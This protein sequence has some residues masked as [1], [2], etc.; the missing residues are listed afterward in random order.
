MS[1]IEINSLSHTYTQGNEDYPVLK[2]I[3]LVIREG[4]F[5]A[6][7]GPSG[8]GKS[9]LLSILA[10]LE[11]PTKG[12]YQLAGTSVTGLNQDQ[13]AMLRGKHIGI[14]FQSFNLIGDMTLAENIQLPLK[15]SSHVSA[16]RHSLLVENAIAAVGLTD[17]ADFYPDMLSGGQQQRAAI[18]RAIVHQPDILFADEPTGN[19][20]S[21]TGEHI[22]N[23][24]KDL[25]DKGMTLCMVTHD[26]SIAQQANS[27]LF[28]QDGRISDSV[29]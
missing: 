28:M 3:N 14:I 12:A 11:R 15:L 13:R 7:C 8:H 27:R 20:D 17:K 6:I 4:E 29:S 24:L 10:L 21:T 9:T 26:K 25:N 2:E 5:T 23:L 19:L 18:A 16:E 1:L 22:M